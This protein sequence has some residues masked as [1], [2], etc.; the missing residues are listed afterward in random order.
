MKLALHRTVCGNMPD[1]TIQLPK[2]WLYILL[3]L[4]GMVL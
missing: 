2:R 3:H 1:S 4:N